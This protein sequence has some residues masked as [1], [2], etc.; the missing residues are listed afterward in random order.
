MLLSMLA[1]GWAAGAETP[2]KQQQLLNDLPRLWAAAATAGD[3]DS[4]V[5]LYSDDAFIHVVFTSD[6]LHGR[7]QIAAY[8][9]KY[10]KTPQKVTITEVE[11]SSIVATVGLLSGKALVEFAGQPPMR[12]RFSIVAN[13]K[14]D[15][16]WVQIYYAS[17]LDG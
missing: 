7:E 16:W 1:T 14:N 17:R 11:E 13:W 9:A 15:R 8:Y 3:V 4:L 2:T 6:E 10:A 5:G 12:T